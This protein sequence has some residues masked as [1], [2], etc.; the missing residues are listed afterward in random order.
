MAYIFMFLALL[1][2]TFNWSHG[3]L[4]ALGNFYLLCLR[5]SR[6]PR[7]YSHIKIIIL[8]SV[9]WVICRLIILIIMG[10]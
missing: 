1:D 9:I 2:Y 5:I 8:I 4:I 6:N 7:V 10:V 3:I